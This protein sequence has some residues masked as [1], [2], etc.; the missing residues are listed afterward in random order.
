MTSQDRG[1]LLHAAHRR[2]KLLGLSGA[3][4]ERALAEV[5]EKPSQKFIQVGD[6]PPEPAITALQSQAQQPSQI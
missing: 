3:D 6:H 5:D 1:N 2:A 4:Y